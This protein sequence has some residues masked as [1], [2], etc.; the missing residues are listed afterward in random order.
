MTEDLNDF[1]DCDGDND[2]TEN[3]ERLT[4]IVLLIKYN[5]ILIIRISNHKESENYHNEIIYHDNVSGN[6]S[7][8]R[9]VSLNDNN[10]SGPSNLNP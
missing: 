4:S 8:E 6:Q 3:M 5:K 10:S 2:Y 9:E 1:D 7:N